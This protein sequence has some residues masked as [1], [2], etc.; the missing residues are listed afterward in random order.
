MRYLLLPVIIVLFS[1]CEDEKV[2]ETALPPFNDFWLATNFDLPSTNAQS[3]TKMTYYNTWAEV[4]N[5]GADHLKYYAS[6]TTTQQPS[7]T[8]NPPDGSSLLISTNGNIITIEAA[9]VM[10]KIGQPISGE[11][12]EQWA[13]TCNYSATVVADVSES[14]IKSAVLT[15]T[16]DKFS[17]E[18]DLSQVMVFGK[19]DGKK[20]E[21]PEWS[22]S[23]EED[24][25]F[26]KTAKH[27]IYLR[28]SFRIDDVY[29]TAVKK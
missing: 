21:L 17:A 2:A 24:E 22:I 16:S 27:K 6:N 1:S 15:V 7:G 13:S 9:G 25:V 4:R 26:D 28:L 14:K 12:T 19:N 18:Y 23:N 10:P 11:N 3:F 20:P 5:Q 8:G 29:G